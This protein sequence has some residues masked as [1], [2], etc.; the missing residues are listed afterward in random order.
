MSQNASGHTYS[1]IALIFSGGKKSM[2]NK[3]KIS[4]ILGWSSWL[5]LEQ[6]NH[7]FK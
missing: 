3:E 5:A 2:R 1:K 6:G 4:I 7:V